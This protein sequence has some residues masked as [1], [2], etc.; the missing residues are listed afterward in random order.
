MKIKKKH[1]Y[2]SKT[3]VGAL[4]VGISAVLGTVGGFLSGSIEFASAFQ[5]LLI[6]V[7]AIVGFFGLRDLPFV[8]K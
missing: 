3:K 5:A 6:E 4:L 1:F 2:E 8:N 7:G